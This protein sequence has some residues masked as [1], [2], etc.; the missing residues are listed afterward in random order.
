[1]P[2]SGMQPASTYE[3]YRSE[4]NAIEQVQVGLVV[5]SGRKSGLKWAAGRRQGVAVNMGQQAQQIP[6]KACHI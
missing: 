3:L 4:A 6:C 5:L 1:M 2:S